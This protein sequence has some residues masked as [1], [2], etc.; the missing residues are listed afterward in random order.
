MTYKVPAVVWFAIALGWPALG[1]WCLAQGDSWSWWM[2]AIC[3]ANGAFC[4]GRGVTLWVKANPSG[5][6]G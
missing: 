3:T 5:E 4:G 1:G 2:L 6:S